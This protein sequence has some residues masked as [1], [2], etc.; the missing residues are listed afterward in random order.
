M[1][2]SLCLIRRRP[3]VPSTAIIQACHFITRNSRLLCC[4][5]PGVVTVTKL[6]AAPCGT[7]AVANPTKMQR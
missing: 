5:P 6:L 7:V 3:P 1:M 2:M 4:V